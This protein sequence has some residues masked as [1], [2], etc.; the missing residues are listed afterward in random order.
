MNNNIYILFRRDYTGSQWNEDYK[1]TYI[2]TFDSYE[3]LR[4][5]CKNKQHIKNPDL[6]YE[7][8]W[9]KIKEIKE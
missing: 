3:K 2:D 1:D 7:G 9:Y 8:F 4:K 5:A 6:R